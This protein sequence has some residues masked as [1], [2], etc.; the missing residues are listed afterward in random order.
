MRLSVHALQAGK[1][2]KTSVAVLLLAL[3]AVG[4]G[5]E[6]D[7]TEDAEPQA[8]TSSTTA[9]SVASLDL[10]SPEAVVSEF[11]DGVRRGGTAADIGRLMTAKAREQY[12][13]VGLVMQPLGAPDATFK[14]TRSVP[15]GDGAVL[16]NSVWSEQ[17]AEGEP[18]SYEVAWA[19][20]NEPEGW[21][22]SGLILGEDQIFNFES[23][24]D[25]LAIKGMQ[26]GEPAVGGD[27]PRTADGS[28]FTMPDFN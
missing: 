11:L 18:V 13:A 8:A 4:C 9:D 2:G 26:D 19:L 10:Q 14:V 28:G 23:R 27:V 6:P 12:A 22:V 16:V 25:V 15:Y 21:R 3:A 20:K 7:A 17:S 5:G 24:D 1:R